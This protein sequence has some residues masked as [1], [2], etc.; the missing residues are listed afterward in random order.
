MRAKW[1]EATTY[2]P[3]I[4]HIDKLV[5]KHILG[6]RAQVEGTGPAPHWTKESLRSYST[7]Y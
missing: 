6:D 5:E 7:T 2:Q 1:R 3:F 4:A